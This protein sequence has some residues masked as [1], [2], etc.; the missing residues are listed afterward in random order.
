MKKVIS[1]L[2]A[3]AIKSF[4]VYVLVTDGLTHYNPDLPFYEQDAV[5][6]W[7]LYL[8]IFMGYEAMI[9][10]VGNSII[11][12]KKALTNEPPDSGAEK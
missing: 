1:V 8:P 5:V 10:V 12:I 6:F 2:I 9:N 3:L 11:S 4:L 7:L